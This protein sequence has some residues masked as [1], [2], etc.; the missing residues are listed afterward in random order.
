MLLRL[1]VEDWNVVAFVF[2]HVDYTYVCVHVRVW[3]FVCGNSSFCPPLPPRI[4]VES[5]SRLRDVSTKQH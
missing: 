2:V 1:C 5:M 3:K 4:N